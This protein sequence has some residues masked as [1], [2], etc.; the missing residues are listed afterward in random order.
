[1]TIRG[2]VCAVTFV[3]FGWV[4]I[5]MGVTVLS[6]DAPAA[7]VIFPSQEFLARMP[8]GVGIVSASPISVT[9]ASENADLALQLYRTGAWFVLPAGLTG[10]FARL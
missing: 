2:T 8:D 3:L 7:L 10:C 5:L 4:A 9:V 1:M 6:D